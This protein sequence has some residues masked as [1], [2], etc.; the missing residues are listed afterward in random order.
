MILVGGTE[1]QVLSI[2]TDNEN[3]KG[4]LVQLMCRLVLHTEPKD[5]THSQY[6][7]HDTIVT[8]ARQ[9]EYSLD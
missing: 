5:F 6:C 3:G 7:C 9:Q 4:V 8:Q 1:T 2:Q